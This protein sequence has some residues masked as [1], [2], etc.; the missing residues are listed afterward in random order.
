MDAGTILRPT[1]AIWNKYCDTVTLEF[2][3]EDWG[4]Y[5][6]R[7]GICWPSAFSGHSNLAADGFAVL[8][9]LDTRTRIAY[10][11]EES[12]FVSVGPIVGR[13]GRV[14]YSGLAPW[15][16]MCW[17]RYYARFFYFSQPITTHNKY[18]LHILRCDMVD[19][20]PLFK[21]LHW[22]DIS[23]GVHTIFEWGAQHRFYGWENSVTHQ[24][25]VEYQGRVGIPPPAPVHALM[26]ALSGLDK[27]P[28]RPRRVASEP[29]K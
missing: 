27:Y 20:K 10:L 24:A 12:A 19:P 26:C 21:E 13:G 18:L 4:E 9:G 14:E 3:N 25:M 16:N 22:D 5:Q 23:Q 15:L 8:L 28:W 2:S 6:L 1:A 7:G 29:G 17:Q 11:F